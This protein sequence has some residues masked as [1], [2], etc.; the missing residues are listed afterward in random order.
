VQ[1]RI[2]REKHFGPKSLKSGFKTLNKAKKCYPLQT[3]IRGADDKI[4]GQIEFTEKIE[5]FC[6][7]SGQNR[8]NMASK[9][10]IK[11]KIVSSAPKFTFG[12][13]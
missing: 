12:V 11:R 5:F 2:P 7:K 6:E 9:L 4:Y 1:V 3:C 10:W 8:G 13:G